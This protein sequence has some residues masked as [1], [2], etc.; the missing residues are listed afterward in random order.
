MAKSKKIMGDISQDDIKKNAHKEQQKAMG[1]ISERQLEETETPKMEKLKIVY[2]D[3]KHHS[4]AKA[5]AALRGMKLM[6]YI[7][8]LIAQD[9]KS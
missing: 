6:N 1:N 9:K 8:Y 4:Q 5:A 3:T 7:E 2:V